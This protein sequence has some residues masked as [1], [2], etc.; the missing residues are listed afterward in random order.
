MFLLTVATSSTLFS[1]YCL[2]FTLDWRVVLSIFQVIS[3][4]ICEKYF[5]AVGVVGSALL[6]FF[7]AVEMVWKFTYQ[8]V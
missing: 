4:L 5:R 1:G 2:L 6:V 3:P 7:V 8:W